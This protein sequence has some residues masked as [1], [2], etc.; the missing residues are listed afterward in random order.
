GGIVLNI[1]DVTERMLAERALEQAMLEAERAREAAERANR[2]KS[3]FLSRMSHELRTPMNSILGFAQLL[4][5]ADIPTD[6]KRG[7]QHI[8]KAGRHL[9][10]LINEVLEIA[11]IESGRQNFSLEPVRLRGVLQ[12]AVGLV[13]PLAAQRSVELDEGPWAHDDTFVRADRQ[14]LVQVLLNLLSNGVTHT[15]AG[16]SVRLSCIPASEGSRRLVVLVRDTGVGIPEERRDE[17]FTPFSRLGAEQT[18]VEGT[19]LGLA[20]SQRLA[21]AMGGI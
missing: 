17:L 1:R 5:R 3:E 9:L 6:Q 8:L 4:D 10:H 11:K 7:V 13:R 18:D 20:L 16:G 15:R 2:A 19:G 21:E 14:R 12:E